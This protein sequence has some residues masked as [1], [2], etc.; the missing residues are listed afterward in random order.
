[1]RGGDLHSNGRWLVYGANFDFESGMEIGPTWVC[2]HD[3]ES[4]MRKVLARAEKASYLRPRLSPDGRF[5][6]Y[7]KK[8]LHPAGQQ[9][10]LV[11]IEGE[12]NREILNFGAAVKSSAFWFPDGKSLLVISETS[13]HK[14][15]GIWTLADESLQ[16]LID[17]PSRSI[18]EAYVSNGSD[19]IV[20]I[21]VHQARVHSSLFNLGTGAETK[22][23]PP[24]GTVIPLAPTADG[25]WVGQSYSSRQPDDIVSFEVEDSGPKGLSSIS[26]VWQRTP[27]S[28]QDLTQAQAYHWQSVDG[29]QIQGWLYRPQGEPQGMIVYVHGGPTSHSMDRINVQLQLFARAG[30]VVLDP[31][32]RGSTGFGLSF[33]EAIKKEGWGGVEQEDIRSG[34]EAL[35]TD[36]IAQAG[37]VGITG[38]SYGGYSSWCAITRYPVEIVTAAVPICG[39]TDL[40]IDYET[41][42]PDLRPYSEE[43]MGGSPD[44]LL[45]K[46]NERS[47]I[48]FVAN[49]QGSLLIVQ[50]NRDPNVTPEN[51]RAV[52][53][54]LADAGIAYEILTFDDEGHGIS[55]VKNK[56]TLYLAMLEFFNRIVKSGSSFSSTRPKF[57]SDGVP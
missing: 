18:E 44:E 8:D 23:A 49:I 52:E 1:L 45:D 56:K 50:G 16:W 36:G 7:T 26:A 14:R 30:F 34:I 39:M 10:W 31:N 32:Y 38:T 46:Y 35:I 17:D 13:T 55:K 2:R 47:P 33:R 57:H 42:R 53:I 3:L 6:L 40:V 37:K 22:L 5:V 28:A 24:S 4:G 20:I 41:T 51:V 25:K 21:E 27:L 54:A 48:N 12:G 19:E 11:G 15:V 43:M 29:L 9:V